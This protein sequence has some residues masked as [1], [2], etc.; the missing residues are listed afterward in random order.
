MWR[1]DSESR[2]CQ[3]TRSKKIIQ[4]LA[5]LSFIDRDT[6][7]YSTRARVIVELVWPT[8]HTAFPQWLLSDVMCILHFYELENLFSDDRHV[9][10]QHHNGVF[11]LLLKKSPESRSYLK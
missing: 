8:M 6:L 4:D 5:W 3:H 10:E 9:D 1:C 7:V 11:F 2:Q